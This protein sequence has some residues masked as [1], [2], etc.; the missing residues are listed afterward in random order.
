MRMLALGVSFAVLASSAAFAA[1]TAPA[2]P[3]PLWAG[4]PDVA[5][6]QKIE[7]GHIDAAK[8]SI[9][10]I[11]EAQGRRTIENTLVPY[12]T[13]RASSIRRCTSRT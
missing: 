3:P 9:E 10:K 5:A 13:R 4:K 11:R 6:F 7:D 12:A 2:L 1:E 8:R